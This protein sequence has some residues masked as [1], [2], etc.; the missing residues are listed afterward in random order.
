MSKYQNI[1]AAWINTDKNGKKYI[2]LKA[3]R[4]IKA[5]ESVNLFK[6]DKGGVDTRPDYR[7]YEKIEEDQHDDNAD[8]SEE[9][10]F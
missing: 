10:P 6:N 5:G 8:L 4:D 2:S 3:E 7:A 9:I 1:A